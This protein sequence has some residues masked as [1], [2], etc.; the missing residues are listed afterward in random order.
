MARLRKSITVAHKIAR[1][2]LQATQDIMKRDYDL[3]MHEYQY[4]PGD[5][6]YVLDT[7]VIKGKNR[8]LSPPWKGPGIVVAKITPYVYKIKFRTSVFTINH[9]RLKR[10][11]DR[12]VPLWL[13]R[14]KVRIEA[15][16]D[17]SDDKTVFVEGPTSV[18]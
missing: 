14:W 8:K 12:T 6:V 7:A 2:T 18:S 11:N 10:C 17:V 13:D 15:G 4:E 3:R 9:D 1:E 16:E 5:L